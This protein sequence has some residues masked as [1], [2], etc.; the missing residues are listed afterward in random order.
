M[1]M[2]RMNKLINMD[3]FFSNGH[4]LLPSARLTCKAASADVGS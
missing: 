1:C 4:I 3:E 2:C